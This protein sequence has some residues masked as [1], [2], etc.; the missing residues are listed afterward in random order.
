MASGRFE[1]EQFEEDEALAGEL[2]RLSPA[3]LILADEQCYPESA[4]NRVG[5]R[6]LPPWEFDQENAVTLLTRQFNT[7]DLAGFGCDDQPVALGAAGALLGY[8]QE[9]QRT[10]LPHIQR[11]TKI[12]RENAIII[13]A[14]SRRNLE[15]DTNLAGGTDNTLFQV[16]DKTATPMGGRLLKRW[17][18]RPERDR[19]VLNDRLDAVDHLRD[20][21][22]FESL[23]AHLERIGDM[24][25][26]LARVA[27]K[28]A[29]PRDLARLR[30]APP[31]DTGTQ[32]RAG[33]IRA[34]SVACHRRE[35]PPLS[36]ND[37]SAEAR[38]H[39]QS[40]RGGARRRGDRPRL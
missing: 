24:E 29:R 18:N 17:I 12:Q 2:H 7:R 3:E 14:A 28:S 11:L 36:T 35:G 1:V 9:T 38:D 6:R 22:R 30:D 37:R 16:M 40:A 15:L 8:V 34:R 33:G 13:D 23:Q 31:G 5:L 21:Y 39:R 32:V 4:Q 19:G 27:L 20:D 25:R 26:I 10:A